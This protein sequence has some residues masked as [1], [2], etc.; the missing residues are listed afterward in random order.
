M[1]RRHRDDVRP[2]EIAPELIGDSPAWREVCAALPRIAQSDLPVLVLGE[3]GTGKELVARAVHAWS[4]R[5]A[6]S[7]VAHNCGATPDTLIES[8]LFGH[9]R[10]AFT[11]AVADRAGLF[12][13]AD[14]GTLFLDEIG[15]ASALLQMKLL[16]ALQEGEARR[17]GDT[18]VRR[19]DVRVVSA[20][21]RGLE[22]A[23]AASGFRADL[24][25][26]LNAVRV[27]LPPLRERGHDILV[28]ARAF[29]ARAAAACGIEPPA[30]APAL[31]QRLLHYR[32][33]GNVRE[34]ANGCA[35][36]VRVAGA[37]G[38]IE[39][40][41]WPEMAAAETSAARGLHAETRALEEKRLREM[42]ERTRWNKSR[43]AKALG[44]SRQGLLK[45][46]RRYGLLELAGG[47]SGGDGAV[48]ALDA[49]ET[50]T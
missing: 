13:A 11:G 35:Y 50:R 26:R 25:Y 22:D 45:K 44:L 28:L 33:P 43:A 31:A 7:F 21:H 3:T 4:A 12:E 38:V 42:L 27:R 8:E 30:I 49:P 20:T 9:A 15:D 23:V 40:W 32:W 41:H 10:G 37:R 46:L 1:E 16:R 14:Q 29:V 39:P 47:G 36:A 6:R 48:A 19:L 24:Y 18:R 5:R 34:L 17:V 2:A